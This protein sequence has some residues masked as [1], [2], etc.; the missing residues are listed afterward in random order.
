MV[1]R[2]GNTNH[3]ASRIIARWRITCLKNVLVVKVD[4]LL[5]LHTEVI[6]VLWT[7]E[8]N[9]DLINPCDKELEESGTK[10]LQ[11]K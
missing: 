4:I 2:M 5:D 6:K 1:D 7:S 10:S 3:A 11:D 8:L 9:M